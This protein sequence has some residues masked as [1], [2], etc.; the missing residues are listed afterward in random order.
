MATFTNQASATY[1]G[2]VIN[3]NVVTGEINEILSVTKAALNECYYANDGGTAYVITLT[4]SGTTPIA[5]VTVT[6]NL[7]AYT[8]GTQTLIPLTYDNDTTRYFING[9]LQQT[10]PTITSSTTSLV[11]S[12]ITIPADSNAMIIYR[13][14]ANE[15]AP[16]AAGS[17][18]TNTATVTGTGV[19]N[20]ATAS[21]ALGV[22]PGAR[23]EITKAVSPVVV[24]DNGELTYT[25]TLL[26][27]GNTAITT[28]DD[29]TVSDQLDPVLNITSVRYN[30]TTTWTNPANYTYNTG[31]FQTVAN[32]IEVPAATN[33][34]DI[35]TGVWTTT[36]GT[37]TITITGTV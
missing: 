7:G 32:Q 14:S 28:A 19:I 35:A 31:L 17:T 27:Y 33:T 22:C 1:N 25:L 20:D 23:L 8:Q 3:S 29:L 16:L 12:D 30:N 34:Q 26:N 18:I 36:P 6:D 11:F 15:F 9:V 5:G 10:T 13:A 21:A 4:N 2:N 24:D 37:A